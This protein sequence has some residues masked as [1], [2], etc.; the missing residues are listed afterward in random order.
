MGVREGESNNSNILNKAYD[1]A[2]DFLGGLF[3]KKKRDTTNDVYY[4]NGVPY[5]NGQKVMVSGSGISVA[6]V[7]GF[8]RAGG[9]LANEKTNLLKPGVTT[10]SVPWNDQGSLFYLNYT[11]PEGFKDIGSLLAQATASGKQL[12]THES[13]PMIDEAFR[14]FQAR[15]QEVMEYR[16]APGRGQTLL[17][18]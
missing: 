10:K 15:K 7:E 17:A 16:G 2:S 9:N 12:L 14:A 18:R 5:V 8:L 13:I 11:N 4:V 3:G 6:D 1:G